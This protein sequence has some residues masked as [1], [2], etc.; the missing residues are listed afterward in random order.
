M[1]KLEESLHGLF[2]FFVFQVRRGLSMRI[3]WSYF[4]GMNNIG[5]SILAFADEVAWA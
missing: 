4:F 1:P 2:F 5:R 3:N